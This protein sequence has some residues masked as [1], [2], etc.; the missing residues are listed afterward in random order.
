MGVYINL[1]HYNHPLDQLAC[2]LFAVRCGRAYLNSIPLL[3]SS[4]MTD[5]SASRTG[6]PWS[7]QATGKST[8]H[9]TL[10]TFHPTIVI[11]GQD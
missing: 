2:R 5:I 3:S 11:F 8:L 7:E 6:L 10:S 1:H 4:G 9:F